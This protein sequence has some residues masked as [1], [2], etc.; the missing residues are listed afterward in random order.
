[1][2]IFAARRRATPSGSDS[3]APKLPA[4]HHPTVNLHPTVNIGIITCKKASAFFS[5]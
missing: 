4:C 3:S 1:M 5:C 2:T